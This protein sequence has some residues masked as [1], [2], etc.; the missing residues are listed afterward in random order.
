M[1]GTWIIEE[2]YRINR[3]KSELVSNQ[4]MHTTVIAAEAITMLDLVTAVVRNIVVNE[5]GNLKACTDC[6]IVSDTLTS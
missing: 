3:C 2:D 4:W 1:G 5:S 6:K